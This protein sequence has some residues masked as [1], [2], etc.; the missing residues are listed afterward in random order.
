MKLGDLISFK[1]IGFGKGE[2]SN[3]AI[4]IEEYT[5][6]NSGLWVVFVEGGRFV[7]DDENYEIIIL[8]TS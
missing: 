1:P 2:W 3:P 6:P 5:N 7:I 4:L 8:T